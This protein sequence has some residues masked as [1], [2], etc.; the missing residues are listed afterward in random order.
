ELYPEAASLVRAWRRNP[1]DL[2]ECRRLRRTL[3]TFKG[4][5]RMAG[6]M[7]LGELAHLMETRLAIDDEFTAGTTDLFE[8]LD[9]DL[10]RIGYV[11]DALREGRV[12]V[13]L[14]GTAEALA[15]E[16]AAAAAA[17]LGAAPAPGTDRKTVIPLAGSATVARAA[18]SAEGDA[19][20]R[21]MLRV[22]ADIIDHLVTE[23]GEVSITRTQIEGEMRALKA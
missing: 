9:A 1:S 11:L 5:A 20:A 22:R 12:N 17:A 18:E 8:A 19:G 10:D 15:A 3:H 2:N 14:P 23:A 6:A 7:R 16:K 21:A 4:S 13:P